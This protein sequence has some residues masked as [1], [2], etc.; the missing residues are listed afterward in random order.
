MSVARFCVCGFLLSGDAAKPCPACGRSLAPAVPTTKIAPLP[1]DAPL[2][3][4]YDAVEVDAHD[5]PVP[6]SAADDFRRQRSKTLRAVQDEHRERRRIGAN[7]WPMA[8][9]LQD[10]LMYPLKSIVWVLVLAWSWSA[11]VI[12]GVRLANYSSPEIWYAG[13]VVAL[14]ALIVV[15]FTHRLLQYAYASSSLGRTEMLSWPSFHLV[16]EL[17]AGVRGLAG[18]LMGP[19]PVAFLAGWF[20][21]HSG[22]MQPLDV[23][24][25][26]E[27]VALALTWWLLIVVASHEFGSIDPRRIGAWFET[28]G[29]VPLMVSF[30]VMTAATFILWFVLTVLFASE[31]EGIF[32][33]V[34]FLPA[35]LVWVFALIFVLL[36]WLGV[37][38][39]QP[40]APETAL[41][42][43]PTV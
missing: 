5:N 33:L 26:V 21:L 16:A 6:A 2:H 3:L 27:L 9:T 15:G 1:I 36:R 24:I 14:A 4:K 13:A 42:I 37:R 39:R 18:L 8:G 34:I 25:I 7:P 30:G 22:P 32:M 41:P 17:K 11:L 38:G 20:W 10:C 29:W 28:V 35:A 43:E 12:F 19:L 40:L 31:A 23:L